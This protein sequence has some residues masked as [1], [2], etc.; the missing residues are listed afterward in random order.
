MNFI[1]CEGT[2]TVLNG[3]VSCQGTLVTYT[4]DQ[5]RDAFIGG[6]FNLPLTDLI[7]IGV[8][9]YLSFWATF[10]IFGQIRKAMD[11]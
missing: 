6:I 10:F 2:W 7:G 1:G 8:W 4:A 5:M 3:A 9:A 11:L